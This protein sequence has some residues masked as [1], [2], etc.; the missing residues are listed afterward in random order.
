MARQPAAGRKL[1]EMA[2]A[3]SLLPRVPCVKRHV[4]V[5]VAQYVQPASLKLPRGNYVARLDWVTRQRPRPNAHAGSDI[6]PRV[7]RLAF[8]SPGRL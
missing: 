4:E 8:G 2:A 3:R 1:L 5:L 7:E 6:H